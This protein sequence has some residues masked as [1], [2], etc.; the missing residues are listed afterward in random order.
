VGTIARRQQFH[1]HSQDMLIPQVIGIPGPKPARLEHSFQLISLKA[2]LDK[3][4]G[5]FDQVSLR[6]L[7]RGPLARHVDVWEAT[8]NPIPFPLESGGQVQPKPNNADGLHGPIVREISNLTTCHRAY[9]T[10]ITQKSP[11]NLL[12]LPPQ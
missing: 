9:E 8:H 1:R 10:P 12:K 7:L 5:G 3:K 11:E 2:G 4:L 6:L